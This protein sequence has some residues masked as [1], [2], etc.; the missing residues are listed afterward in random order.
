LLLDLSPAEIDELVSLSRQV[1]EPDGAGTDSN[2]LRHA[3]V[4]VTSRA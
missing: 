4:S 1:S 3:S 2:W